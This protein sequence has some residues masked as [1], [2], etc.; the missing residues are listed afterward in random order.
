MFF[1]KNKSIILGLILL[2]GFSVT[3]LAQNKS[4]ATPVQRLEIMRQKLDALRKSLSST[5][6][7]VK[8][9][10]KEDKSKKDDKEDLNSPLG[11]LKSFDKEGSSLQ[12]EVNNL[13]GKV[14]RAEKYEISDIDSVEERVA[15]YQSR[16]DKLLLETASSR[17]NPVSDIGKERKIKKKGKFLGIFGGGG[18]DEYDELIGSVVPGRDRELFVEATKNVRK[19]NYDVGRLL[20]Q[21][22]ITTY[23][24]SPYLPMAKLAVADSFYLEGSTSALIQASAAY[25]DWLTFFPTH[26]LADRVLLKIAESQMRRIGLPDLDSSNAKVAEQRLKALLQQYPKSSLR[27]EAQK[28]LAEVQDNL[29]LHNLY[30]A[31]YYYK[32]SVDYKKGGLKGAQSRYNEILEKYP[33]FKFM[34]EA[35]YKLA[36]TY[37][38]EEETDQAARYFQQIVSDYPNS[39]WVEKSKEQLQLI[40]ATVPEPNPERMKVLPPEDVSF[41]QNFKNEFFGTY[42]LTIDKDGVLMTDNFDKRKFELIDK[43]IENQGDISES[44]IPKSLTTVISQRQE[45]QTQK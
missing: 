10:N 11:R 37:L 40:G 13:R 43:I 19:N 5:I 20:F 29:G 14:D 25:Q 23:P 26:P 1:L 42:P 32:Q 38:I 16:V 3:G 31:N 8:D 45:N 28:R 4:S 27:D 34:D 22:I 41:I 2:L 30:I 24:D 17:A 35:L 15:E 33:N 7:V 44:Q 12:S 36:V 18:N 9:D 21:T 6:S 39:D